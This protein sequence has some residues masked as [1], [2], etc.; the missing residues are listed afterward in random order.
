LLCW[1]KRQRNPTHL[2]GF[3]TSTQPTNQDFFR[4]GQGIEEYKIFLSQLPNKIESIKTIVKLYVEIGCKLKKIY[5]DRDSLPL[6][7]NL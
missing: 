6:S 3:L 7:L 5:P 4:F 1:V 2:L